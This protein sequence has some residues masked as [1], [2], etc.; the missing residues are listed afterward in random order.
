MS[1]HPSDTSVNSST[2]LKLD[3]DRQA[4]EMRRPY[5]LMDF[6]EF[7]RRM[8]CAD[9]GARRMADWANEVAPPRDAEFH[10]MLMTG[11]LVVQVILFIIAVLI[12]VIVGSLVS[13]NTYLKYD[14]PRNECQMTGDIAYRSLI[15]AGMMEA[16]VELKTQHMIRSQ[17]AMARLSRSALDFL[18]HT[19]RQRRLTPLL[20][21]AYG[22]QL[23][24]GHS[25]FEHP[26]DIIYVA[27]RASS[28]PRGD[29]QILCT[30]STYP[31][32]HHT[33]QH[34]L[35][36]FLVSAPF[37]IVALSL[38]R[39]HFNAIGKNFVQPLR[40]L[41]EDM[42]AL[43]F[44][45]FGHRHMDEGGTKRRGSRTLAHTSQVL[46][47]RQLQWS[48]DM[49]RSGL[50]SFSKYVPREVVGITIRRGLPATLETHTRV[51][52][53][54]FSDIKNFTAISEALDLEDLL[55]L[56]SEFFAEMTSVI[57]HY[58]GTLIEFIGDAI[59]AVWNAPL[60]VKLHMSLALA[61]SLEM[62]RIVREKRPKWTRPLAPGF[63]MRCGVHTARVMVGNMGSPGRIK[64]GVLGDGVNLASRLE[65]L[66]NR[67]GTAILTTEVL[68][69]NSEVSRRYILR[70][71]DY[72]VVKGRR[73]STFLYEVL[74]HRKNAPEALLR[75]EALQYEAM[76]LY[77]NKDFDLAN[78]KFR[79]IIAD[80]PAHLT[81]P[82]SILHERSISFEKDPPSVWPRAEQ[83]HHKYF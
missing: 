72:V 68:A 13:D 35:L 41:A 28:D 60:R 57:S 77:L 9:G 26:S 7:E 5:P 14:V 74:C 67:Y 12:C 82:V 37:I 3:Q 65:E 75:L 58:R 31:L 73:K 36:F 80:F 4:E 46:E 34:N 62:Q 29:A 24:T 21:S 56:L 47:I 22:V 30:F 6:D 52:T 25:G 27:S 16:E 32:A 38:F 50:T 76:Q 18:L 45:D 71:L 11:K 48:F 83:L 63:Y 8:V 53:V 64:F 79:E 33:A 55:S 49:M 43:A 54:F 17:E 2:P 70:P 44:L 40:D 20:V 51:L 23:F 1:D 61:A 19:T 69:E 81:E 10:A 39:R 78:A 66:N 59:L 42:E 15:N